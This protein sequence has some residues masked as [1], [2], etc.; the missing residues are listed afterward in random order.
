MRQLIATTADAIQ[1][2][3][4]ELPFTILVIVISALICLFI[5]R[6]AGR[7]VRSALDATSTKGAS[8]A[9]N[10]TRALVI[11]LYCYFVGENVLGLELGGLVQALGVTTLIVSLG[12][13]DLIKNV[14]AGVQIMVGRLFA[15]GDQITLGERRGEVLD[16][17][18]RQTTIKDRDGNPHLIPNSQL[19]N[20]TFV[21][22]DGR[23]A[24]R[25]IVECEIKPGLDLKRVAADIERFANVALDLKGIRTQDSC[26]VRFMGSTANGVRASIRYFVHDVEQATP[27]ADA[28]V[29]AIAQRGYLADWTN[30]SPDQKPWR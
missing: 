27:G 22:L 2:A 8:L 12:L 29:R 28:I 9:V 25:H 4:G 21:R 26:E 7:A 6:I 23:M 19:M 18:W 20:E 3:I 5:S 15:V 24:N 10:L 11:V 14:V 30:D 17:N 1:A 16:V 13:Q